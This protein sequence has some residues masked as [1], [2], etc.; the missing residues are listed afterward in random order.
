V[1]LRIEASAASHGGKMSLQIP[2]SGQ[3]E[4]ARIVAERSRQA[5]ARLMAV[6]G[7]DLKQP[8]QVATFSI[9][10]AIGENLPARA[11]NRLRIALDA[12]RRLNCELDDIARLSQQHI[13]TLARLQPVD[14]DEILA[15]VERDW[16]DYADTTGTALEINPSGMRVETD[17]AMLRTILRNLVGNA[18]RHAG[19][20]GQVSISCRRHGDRLRISVQDDGSGIPVAH[21]S[22][23]FDAFARCGAPDRDDGLGLGL[24]IVRQT[25]ELLQHPLSVRSVEHEGST[26]SIELPLLGPRLPQT[27]DADFARTGSN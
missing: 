27:I 4:E 23:I 20:R 8:I 13:A 12:M 22:R 15:D 24:T 10:L 14:L 16:R 2:I 21:L 11:A 19:P 3:A 9:A 6:A 1:A 26:F 17:P 7:H 18:I 25:A 5:M